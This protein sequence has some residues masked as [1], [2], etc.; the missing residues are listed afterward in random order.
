[1]PI[2]AL[3]EI[4]DEIVRYQWFSESGK[5]RNEDQIPWSTILELE[6]FKRDVFAYDLICLTIKHSG[7][8]SVEIDE[9]DLL[10]EVFVSSLPD[11]LDGVRPWSEWFTEVAFPAFETK[12][13]TIY[14]RL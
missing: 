11:R 3:L 2:C 7:G 5:I 8:E 10:W 13:Q 14:T 4:N 1:M 6:V 9:E 12:N